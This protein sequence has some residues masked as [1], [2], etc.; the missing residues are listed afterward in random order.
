[1][2][3]SSSAPRTPAKRSSP[4]DIDAD[5]RRYVDGKPRYDGVAAFLEVARDRGAVGRPRTTPPACKRVQ[6]L[7]NLKD[8]YFMQHLEQH[9]VEVYEASIALVRTLR[10]QEI[11]TAVVSSSNNCAAVLEAAGIS[12]LFDARVDGTDITR[13]GLKGKPAP[14]AFLEAAR[15]LRTEPS[16]AVVVEDA[17]VG[18]EAG[19]AGRFGLRHRRRSQRA[20][21]GAARGR[22]RCR[23]DQPGAGPG[24]S[25]AA[26]GLVA[27]V[28]GLRPGARGHPRGPV[29]LGKRLLRDARG[30]SLGA[31]RR[32]PL[33][34]HLPRRRLQPAAHRYR[35]PGGRERGPRQFSQL[36]RA[37]VPHRR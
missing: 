35:R 2:G 10:A 6:A 26:F 15:R 28:R 9:G 19:R 20:I 36:A 5:Y 27:G 3:F 4:F 14:D 21:A 37:R 34:R 32:H 17:I 30:G 8:H 16:R 23:G 31:G 24:G 25:G 1:M 29:R 33:S 11:K 7:G 13:L 18:V 22:R 12:Q